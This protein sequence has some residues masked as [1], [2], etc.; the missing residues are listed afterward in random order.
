MNRGRTL[1]AE[2]SGTQSLWLG[3]H[4]N[5]CHTV[6]RMGPHHSDEA[7]SHAGEGVELECLH[8]QYIWPPG[9]LCNLFHPLHNFLNNFPLRVVYMACM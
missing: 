2:T 1:S 8:L 7:L 3:W 9:H 6:V 4:H 5:R